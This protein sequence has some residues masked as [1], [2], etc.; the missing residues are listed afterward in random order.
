MKIIVE[1]GHGRE[2]ILI[3][4]FGFVIGNFRLGRLYPDFKEQFS[5]HHDYLIFY[6]ILI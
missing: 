6:L 4:T 2:S 3:G 5:I 1:I